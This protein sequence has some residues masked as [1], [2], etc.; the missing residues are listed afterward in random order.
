MLFGS[1][2]ILIK[3]KNRSLIEGLMDQLP[4]LYRDTVIPN[5][6]FSSAIQ[7]ALIAMVMKEEKKRREDVFLTNTFV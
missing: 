6:A 4:I 3:K 1:C 2:V 5:A 7:S